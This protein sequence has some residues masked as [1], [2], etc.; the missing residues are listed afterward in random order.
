[1]TWGKAI[2][3]L[4]YTF[5]FIFLVGYL[6]YFLR[7]WLI[8]RQL[9]VSKSRIFTKFLLRSLYFTL[10][11]MA[12]LGPSFDKSTKEIQ[13]VGKDIFVCLDLSESMNAYDI[14]PTRLEKLKFE[15]KGIVDKFSSDRI[16]LI[17]FAGDA[18]IQCPL[19]YDKSALNLFIETLSTS[20]VQGGGTDF[21]PPLA[22]ALEKFQNTESGPE[23]FS[24]KIILLISDGEDFGETTGRVIEEINKTGIKLFALGIGTEKGSRIHSGRGFKLNKNGEE[25]ITRLD[26]S[27]LKKIAARTNGKYFEISDNKNEIPKLIQTLNAIE[28]EVKEKRS[29]DATGNKYYLFLAL[30]MMLMSLDLLFQF[31]V[32]RL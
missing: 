14:M 16:G 9:K 3:N 22:L 31:N 21:G 20:L 8:S 1:M 2:S 27:S 18:F 32:I 25:L 29:V 17:I 19:T 23:Q 28:G 10:F 13:A 7:M 26:A 11:I 15:L 24:S 6:S 30:A 12:L 5:I 4:E